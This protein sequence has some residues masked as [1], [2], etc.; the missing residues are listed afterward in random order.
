[1]SNFLEDE[2]R[3]R[4][5]AEEAVKAAKTLKDQQQKENERLAGLE[6]AE[7]AREVHLKRQEWWH[8]ALYKGMRE[9]YGANP[10]DI[11]AQVQQVWGAGEIVGPHHTPDDSFQK[12]DFWARL[13]YEYDDFEL[14]PQYTNYTVSGQ[15]YD[16]YDHGSSTRQEFRGYKV[17]PRHASTHLTIGYEAKYSEAEAINGNLYVA[18]YLEPF[19]GLSP[20]SIF[21][22][23]RK[24]SVG[25]A[26]AIKEFIIGDNDYRTEKKGLPLLIPQGIREALEAHR[27]RILPEN[28]NM[29]EEPAMRKNRPF[30]K[31]FP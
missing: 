26:E 7:R 25:D 9:F 19:G 29:Q 23:T 31:I 5:L 12:V 8:K 4:K 6:A 22:H 11:L 1:M 18:S 10:L 15:G 17:L 27:D 28:Q 30:W 3:R 20:L 24:N 16:G 14:D 13:Q 21:G 2:I